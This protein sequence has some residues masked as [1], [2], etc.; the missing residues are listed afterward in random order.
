[1]DVTGIVVTV[2][3]VVRDKFDDTGRL[4]GGMGWM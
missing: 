1:M 4:R 2:Q 3:A